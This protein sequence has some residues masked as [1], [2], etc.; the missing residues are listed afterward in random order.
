MSNENQAKERRSSSEF[1]LEQL[2]ALL[3]RNLSGRRAPGKNSLTSLL[4]QREGGANPAPTHASPET[5][6]DT[7]PPAVAGATDDGWS[8]NPLLAAALGFVPGGPLLASALAPRSSESPQNSPTGTL[9]VLGV[10]AGAAVTRGRQPAL[11]Y[12][13]QVTPIGGRNLAAGIDAGAAG[14][15]RASVEQFQVGQQSLQGQ[16]RRDEG[17]TV[18]SDVSHS[19]R[20]EVTNASLENRNPLGTTRVSGSYGTGPTTSA[21]VSYNPETGSAEAR[22]SWKGGGYKLSDVAM[23]GSYLGDRVRVDG[24]A[25]EWNTANSYAGAIGW[26]GEAREAYARGQL[27]TGTTL[28]NA[29]TGFDIGKGAVN[30]NAGVGEWIHGNDLSGELRIGEQGVRASGDARFGGHRI[31]NAHARLGLGDVAETSA[32]VGSA[33][34]DTL[35]GGAKLDISREGVDARLQTLR[36]GGVRMRGIETQTSLMGLENRSSLGAVSNDTKIDGASA[37]IGRDGV[38]LGVDEADFAGVRMSD[39][40]SHTR[41]GAL[42]TDIGIGSAS[43]TTN[44]KGGRA[45]FDGDGASL[46]FQELRTGGVRARDLQLNAELFGQ[47]IDARAGAVSNDTIMQG[48]GLEI[49]DSGVNARLQQLRTGG[50]RARDMG[51]DMSAM[52]NTLTGSLGELSND[53]KLSGAYSNINFDGTGDMGFDELEFG[54]VRARNAQV[55][56]ASDPLGISGNAGFGEFDSSNAIRG[57]QLTYNF[58]SAQDAGIGAHAD[59]VSALGTCVKNAYFGIQ[60]PGGSAANA[61]VAELSNGLHMRDVDL[62]L[63]KNGLEA[64]VGQAEYSTLSARDLNVDTNLG[65]LYQGQLH[66]GEGHYNRFAGENLALDINRDGISASGDNL[67]YGY[68]GASD[69]EAT[70]SQFGGLLQTGVKADDISALGG[71]AEHLALQSNLYRQSIAV[72]GLSAHGLSVNKGELNGSVG[73]SGVE[74]GG[75]LNADKLELLKLQ[76]E[77]IKGET[78]RFGT[79]GQGS[80]AGVDL[81]LANIENGHAGISIGGEEIVG[82]SGDYEAEMGTDSAQAD[83]DLLSGKANASVQGAQFKQQ[84]SDASFNFA[85]HE[86]QLPD[87]GFNLQ[88][89]AGVG[90]DISRGAANGNLDL[91]GSSVN[92]AGY[93]FTAGDWAR[94]GADLDISRGNLDLNLF[95]Q[96]IDVDQ[97]IR[98]GYKKLKNLLGN[99]F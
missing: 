39:L 59:E 54:G 31:N 84:L 71:S 7:A 98:N 94:V 41:V 89:D 12:G 61:N 1:D 44:I 73:I 66:I 91:S 23:E 99:L 10:K 33:S 19:K 11:D 56:F 52:G 72:D 50:L 93:E 81:S 70:S 20:T 46:G 9:D 79:K 74:V 36:T 83:W 26:N 25:G 86:I 68:A 87:A 85:G 95:G 96:E 16:V 76:A 64:R 78:E 32:R 42:S 57:G 37:H 47:S 30:G 97:G 40:S 88:A 8:R 24:R 15:T 51:F 48:G 27:S 6:R 63:D 34:N 77:Q 5:G 58:A 28:S 49:S 69:V 38:R 55:G 53:V 43:T 67:S 65:S 14:S 60:G 80:A 29:S 90:V 82:V 4:T 18:H 22:A 13:A 35:V 17:G 21:G 92:I 62:G 2:L 75:Q 3:M 45:Q